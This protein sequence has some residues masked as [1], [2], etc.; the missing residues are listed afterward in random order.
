MKKYERAIVILVALV[1]LSAA[2]I[3]VNAI[4]NVLNG[5][6]V[7]QP[8]RVNHIDIPAPTLQMEPDPIVNDMEDQ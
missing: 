3:A 1:L 8:Y 6:I 4:S 5:P 2:S 7:T